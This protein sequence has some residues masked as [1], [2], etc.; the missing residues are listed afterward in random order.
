MLLE[1]AIGDAYGAG[2]EYVNRHL[3]DQFNNLSG[4]IQH[5]R[6]TKTKPGMYT[7]DTQMTLAIVETILSGDHWTPANLARRFV[8]VF[9]RDQREGYAG[10]FY[11][12]LCHVRDGE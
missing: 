9:K 4:Y 11:E 1:L 5:P 12:F 8:E 7:D 6:H 10:R 3:I 2:F